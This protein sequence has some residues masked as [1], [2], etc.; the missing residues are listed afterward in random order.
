VADFYK[1]WHISLG[2]FFRDYVYIPLGGN[3]RYQ[4][5]NIMVV[6]LLTGLWHGAS[7]NFV[8]WGGYFGV[9]MII[10]KMLENV[11]KKVPRFFKHLYTLYLIILSRAIFY[12]VDFSKLR[13]FMVK[14]FASTEPTKDAFYTDIAS[15]SYWFILVI[16]L[17]IPFNE[18]FKP[19]TTIHQ[20]TIAG[21]KIAEPVVNIAMLAMATI[22]LL[23]SSYN[24]FIY[25]RF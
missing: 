17:C 11:L 8:I 21:Y 1:R 4:Y 14:L 19:H 6:W 25:F 16:L 10:E 13:D 7:W 9:F 24:P 15:H 22:L 3:R 2:T 20:K 18:I 12:F 23:D 5:R